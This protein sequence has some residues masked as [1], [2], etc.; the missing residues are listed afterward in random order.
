MFQTNRYSECELIKHVWAI[1]FE[2]RKKKRQQKTQ[3]EHVQCAECHNVDVRWAS[4]WILYIISEE[5]SQF[6][7]SHLLHM[8]KSLNYGYK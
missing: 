2:W 5:M 3:L 4:V 8:E 7:Y 6:E 1:K